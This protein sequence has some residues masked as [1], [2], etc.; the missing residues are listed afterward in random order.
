MHRHVH[1][2]LMTKHVAC[3]QITSPFNMITS[4]VRETCAY[5]FGQFFYVQA[6]GLLLLL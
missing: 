3:N 5:N 1:T 6:L 4:D 2:T